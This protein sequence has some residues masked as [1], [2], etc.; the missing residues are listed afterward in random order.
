MESRD[1]YDKAVVSRCMSTTA[2]RGTLFDQSSVGETPGKL[3]MITMN[4]E[5][6]SHSSRST[7]TSLMRTDHFR[8]RA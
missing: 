8:S 5:R 4:A 6:H 2:S 1:E 7:M 3:L